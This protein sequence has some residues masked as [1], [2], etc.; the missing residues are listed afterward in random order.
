MRKSRTRTCF[1]LLSVAVFRSSSLFLGLECSGYSSGG[2]S[3]PLLH[4]FCHYIYGKAGCLQEVPFQSDSYFRS[5][6]RSSLPPSLF[7]C[8]TGG[9]LHC[10]RQWLVSFS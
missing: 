3:V 9:T 1:T 10:S 4:F 6:S 8:R 5:A 7:S 2:C